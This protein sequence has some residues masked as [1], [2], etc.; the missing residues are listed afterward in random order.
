MTAGALKPAV[1]FGEDPGWS[2]VTPGPAASDD[3]AVGLS[4]KATGPAA[5]ASASLGTRAR[6]FAAFRF[7]PAGARAFRP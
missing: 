2:A 5:D 1:D 3:A 6:S 7:P 4:T